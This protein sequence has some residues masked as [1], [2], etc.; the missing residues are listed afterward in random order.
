MHRRICEQI[1]D[2]QDPTET[3]DQ[4]LNIDVI[5]VIYKISNILVYKLL[6]IRQ[7]NAK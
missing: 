5:L 1:R 7:A 4:Q 6:R 3:K 2:W